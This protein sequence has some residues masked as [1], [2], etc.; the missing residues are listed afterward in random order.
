MTTWGRLDLVQYFPGEESVQP[1][2]GKPSSMINFLV[3]HSINL[4]HKNVIDEVS[5]L[6]A[7]DMSLPLQH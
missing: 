2:P 5:S 1:H 7:V 3:K 4:R 6:S